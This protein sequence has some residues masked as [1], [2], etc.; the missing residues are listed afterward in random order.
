LWILAA[1]HA[2][3]FLGSLTRKKGAE[4]PPPPAHRRKQICCPCPESNPGYQQ[5]H[6][7]EED[8]VRR[9]YFLK[10]IR[11]LISGA[12]LGG[13]YSTFAPSK[14]T[15]KDVDGGKIPVGEKNP[16]TNKMFRVE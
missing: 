7:K 11:D 14:V 16:R 9:K 13:K 4:H 10:T 8:K 5:C 1:L 15:Y 3:I 12:C 6:R 2:P